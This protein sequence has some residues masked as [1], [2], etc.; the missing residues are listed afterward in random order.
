[1]VAHQVNVSV[2]KSSQVPS[3]LC[4]A[5]AIYSPQAPNRPD[6]YVIPGNII[7]RQRGTLFHPGQHVCLAF[8]AVTPVNPIE[9][10]LPLM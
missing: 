4:S 7:V 9:F 6:Q 1:M 10:P 5:C 8:H 3:P 2:S